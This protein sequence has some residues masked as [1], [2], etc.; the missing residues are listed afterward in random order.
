MDR[1]VEPVG[2]GRGVCYCR[3]SLVSLQCNLKAVVPGSGL[4]FHSALHLTELSDWTGCASKR[5]PKWLRTVGK[6][7]LRHVQSIFF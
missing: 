1:A 4:G 6:E 3:R 7:D 5:L 2:Q